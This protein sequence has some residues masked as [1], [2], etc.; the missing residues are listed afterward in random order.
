[1]DTN[2]HEG[3]KR[4]E[5]RHGLTRF[6]ILPQRIFRQDKQDFFGQ[7]GVLRQVFSRCEHLRKPCLRPPAIC[8]GFADKSAIGRKL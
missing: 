8:D 2:E 5:F 7:G 1:M 4:Q 6:F 3:N